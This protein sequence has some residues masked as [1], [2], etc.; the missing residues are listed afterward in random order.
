MRE[1]E[2]VAIA[3]EIGEVRAAIMAEFAELFVP[4]PLQPDEFTVAQFAQ[5]KGWAHRAT[6]SFLEAKVREGKLTARRNVRHKGKVVNAYRVNGS[7]NENG[8]T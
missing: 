8:R 4:L 2:R 5:M 3:Q 1:R 6:A 7:H